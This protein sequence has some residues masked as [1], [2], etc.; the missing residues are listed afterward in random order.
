MKRYGIAKNYTM[1]NEGKYEIIA[2]CGSDR[3]RRYTILNK[4]S[5]DSLLKDLTRYED[6][7][8]KWLRR[9]DVEKE[10]TRLKDL[11][12]EMENVIIHAQKQF[13]YMHSNRGNFGFSGILTE[14]NNVL[15]KTEGEG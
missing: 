9:E 5:P 10:L 13:E 4:K 11:N 3:L 14:I 7:D 15:A 6:P 12:R 1:P 8:G 2:V